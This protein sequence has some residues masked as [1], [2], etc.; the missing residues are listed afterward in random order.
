MIMASR[1]L[2]RRNSSSGKRRRA[3]KDPWSQAGRGPP[4]T[5]EN[6]TLTPAVEQTETCRQRG[7]PRAARFTIL[8]MGGAQ[9]AK[10]DLIY[11]DCET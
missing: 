4:R 7:R 3:L 8:M 11:R 1:L 5:P 6:R 2:S 10:M 9:S